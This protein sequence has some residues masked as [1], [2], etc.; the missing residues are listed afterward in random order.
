[1]VLPFSFAPSQALQHHWAP[2]QTYIG[3]KFLFNQGRAITAG[4]TKYGLALKGS[5][6]AV[7]IRNTVF[8]GNTHDSDGGAVALHG[9]GLAVLESVTFKSNAAGTPWAC[10][11]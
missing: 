10:Q 5:G 1:M 2:P 8:E 11:R 4:N 3:C 7:T 6:V 9:A